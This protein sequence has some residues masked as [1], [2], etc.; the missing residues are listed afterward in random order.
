[1]NS[2]YNKERAHDLKEAL[3]YVIDEKNQQA[4]LTELGR[5]LISP[6][7]PEGFVIPDLAT[8]Y[9]E[10][11]RK[12]TLSDEEKRK[13]REQAEVEFQVKSERIHTIS[14]LLRAYAL[15]EKD[16]EYVVQGGKVM[17]V[18]ENTGRSDAGSR[19]G[20]M[21]CTRRSNP[22]K[23][24]RSRRKP[25]PTPPLPFKIISGCMKNWLV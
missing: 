5:G 22:R 24:C 3:H 15:Y 6:S 7:D 4:D 14:Q 16:K 1:M 20:A 10:I 17:I 12:K 21:G 23:E 11:D 19:D 25:R 2:D 13:E 18:D 8:T 9:V